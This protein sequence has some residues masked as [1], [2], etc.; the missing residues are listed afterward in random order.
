M[1]RK[2]EREE[3]LLEEIKGKYEEDPKKGIRIWGVDATG[4]P[5]Q[6]LVTSDGKLVVSIG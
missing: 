6:I 2:S 3:K 1:S 4:E 5:R